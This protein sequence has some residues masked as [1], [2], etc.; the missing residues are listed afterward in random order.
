MDKNSILE[1]LT[2]GK[3]PDLNKNVDKCDLAFDLFAQILPQ[4]KV[5]YALGYE[6]NTDNSDEIGFFPNK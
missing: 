6:I 2:E 3:I 5:L 4:L 1:K